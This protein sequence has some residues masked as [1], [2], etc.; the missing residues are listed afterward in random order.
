MPRKPEPKFTVKYVESTLPIEEQ[1]RM[2]KM[3]IQ[4]LVKIAKEQEQTDRKA[5]TAK[6][7]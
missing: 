2:Y 5:K 4:H 7:K 1:E 3:F 6:E